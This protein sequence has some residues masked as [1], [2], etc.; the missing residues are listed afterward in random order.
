MKRILVLALTLSVLLGLLSGCSSSFYDPEA[1]IRAPGLTGE[2]EGVQ[3]ALESAVGT[4]IILKYPLYEGQRTC[5]CQHD[6]DGDGQDEVLAFYQLNSENAVTRINLLKYTD[7]GWVSAQD[8][9]RVGNSLV[10]IS[11]ADIDRDGADELITGWSVYTSKDYQMCIYEYTGGALVQRTSESYTQMLRC[12]INS[13]GYDEI[14]IVLLNSEQKSSKLTFYTFTTDQMSVLASAPLD[15]NV[16]SYTKV[17]CRMINDTSMGVYLDAAKGENA[18]ITELVYYKD[19][20]LITPFFNTDRE[21]T[22]MTLRYNTSVC[23]DMDNDG[24]LDVPF[25]VEVPGYS[26][27]EIQNK[28]FLTKWQSYDG[29]VYHNAKTL[30]TC[31]ADGYT[32]TFPENWESSVSVVYDTAESCATFYQFNPLTETLGEELASVRK[33]GAGEWE[34]T[35]PD[36][37]FLLAYT[38]EKVW[39]ARVTQSELAPTQ[40]AMRSRFSLI[41]TS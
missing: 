37:Y 9:G 11:F 39:A 25:S 8:L 14:G 28:Q 19:G 16:T 26:R 30:W 3:K 20:Q 1:T 18:M 38:S 40:S 33:L 10:E 7:N 24:Y 35:H 4:D 41:T 32:I 36:G 29:K 5:F 22:V 31:T 34:Q 17:Q 2:L 27:S 21:E 12:D 23:T 13:D 6:L 15:G